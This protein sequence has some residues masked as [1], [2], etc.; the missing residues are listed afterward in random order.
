MLRKVSIFFL[1]LCS[2]SAMVAA[3]LKFQELRRPRLD[4]LIALNSQT[5]LLLRTTDW[6]SMWYELNGSNL[7]W[8][9]IAE[10]K[11]HLPSLRSLSE[12]LDFHSEDSSA[13]RQLVLSVDQNIGSW[14]LIFDQDIDPA[15]IERSKQRMEIIE[16][17]Y[18]FHGV[19]EQ[20]SMVR[21]ENLQLYS[22]HESV[23]VQVRQRILEGKAENLPLTSVA[24]SRALYAGEIQVLVKDS[25]YTDCF[26]ASTEIIDGWTDLHLRLTPDQLQL[27]GTET[28]EGHNLVG[29]TPVNCTQINL[30]PAGMK[31][32]V[33]YGISNI[34]RYMASK[35]AKDWTPENDAKYGTNPSALLL[36]W[37]GQEACTFTWKNEQFAMLGYEQYSDPVHA[38]SS[39]LIQDTVHEVD[40]MKVYSSELTGVLKALLPEVRQNLDRMVV[41]DQQLIFST[42]QGIQQLSNWTVNAE[43]MENALDRAN[44]ICSN[45][46]QLQSGSGPNAQPKLMGTGF[47]QVAQMVEGRCYHHLVFNG[48]TETISDKKSSVGEDLV[49]SVSSTD[50]IV[51]GPV[52]LKNHRTRSLD[53]LVQESSGAIKLFNS[54]GTLKWTKKLDGQ[55]L[56]EIRQVDVYKNNKF[57]MLF[58][59]RNKVHLLDINGRD[60]EGFPIKLSS[61]ASAPLAL[62]DYKKTKDYRFVVPCENKKIKYFGQDGKAIKGFKFKG[63]TSVVRMTPKHILIGAKD[64]VFFFDDGGR[65]YLLH[66]SGEVRQN[67]KTKLVSKPVQY[68]VEVGENLSMTKLIYRDS[69]NRL[70]QHFLDGVSEEFHLDS[71]TGFDHLLVDG[72]DDLNR[73]KFVGVTKSHV[74]VYGNGYMLLERYEH[75]VD[76]VSRVYT[77]RVR[78][79]SFVIIRGKNGSTKVFDAEGKRVGSESCVG[80]GYSTVVDLYQDGTIH[81]LNASE[82]GVVN[83]KLR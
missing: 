30:L 60:V 20:F 17:D 51:F 4:P 6:K 35:V 52:A 73:G 78:E 14:L 22:N 50:K 47:A 39:F 45:K 31:N 61:K 74:E 12:A 76:Q 49:W 23:L 75:Q 71:K 15:F 56:G 48:K 83:Y 44:F 70:Y 38:L 21:I 10:Q 36:D 57:Q 40:S 1:V 64:F 33:W 13:C 34:E 81:L 63:A 67:V 26:P 37:W 24:K 77:D 43:F 72:K 58:N 42:R 25:C 27:S 46:F 3:Y 18:G 2:I 80:S 28:A 69:T 9:K 65:I 11:E 41:R 32:F 59:T 79:N 29:Q 16:S 54:A 5:D 7:L 66:R 82:S 68:I 62:F 19:G 53:I 55:I 8:K